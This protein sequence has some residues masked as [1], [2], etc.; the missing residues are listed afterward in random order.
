M[1]AEET[2]CPV[3][4][5]GICGRHGLLALESTRDNEVL[6]MLNSINH[7]RA[8]SWRSIRFWKLNGPERREKKFN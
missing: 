3:I 2:F 8:D 1:S 6:I 5:V 7:L 4:P